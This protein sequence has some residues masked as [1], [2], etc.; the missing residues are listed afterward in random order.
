MSESSHIPLKTSPNGVQGLAMLAP[1]LGIPI[2]I[3]LLGGAVVTVTGIAVMVAPVAV[4]VAL[5]LLFSVASNGGFDSIVQKLFP[6][7]PATAVP[8]HGVQ[9][10]TDVPVMESVPITMKVVQAER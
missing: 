1:V 6:S 8:L 4:P 5:P 10:V 3:H 2:G 9:T 7:V